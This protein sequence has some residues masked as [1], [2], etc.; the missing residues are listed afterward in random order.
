MSDTLRIVHMLPALTKGGAERVAVDLANSSAR[1]GHQVTVVAGWKVDEQVL[2]NRLDREVDVIYMT[3]KPGGKLQ[4]YSAGL[5]W[6]FTNQAWLSRHDVL[7]LHLTQAAVL[8]T[9]LY[10]IRKLRRATGPAIVETYHSVGMAIP[11]RLRAFHAWNCRRRDAIALMALDPY[12]RD[13]IAR[14]PALAVDLI[15]NGIDAPVGAAPEDEVRAYLDRTG[16]PRSAT[17]IVGTVGQFRAERQPQTLARILIDV[18][19]QTP[20]DVHALMCGSGTELDAVR[21]LVVDAGMSA[22][23]TLP[24]V[25][26]EPRLAMSAISIYLT[27]NVGPHTGIAALEAALCGSA[28]VGLQTHPGRPIAESDWIWSSDTP[29]IVAKHILELLGDGPKTAQIVEKQRDFV[30]RHHSMERVHLRYLR[31]YDRA[32]ST[33]YGEK[34]SQD[35]Q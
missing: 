28:L 1:A 35:K 6:V 24:G 20:N 2:R 32:I 15:P 19:R 10:A 26:N 23:F 13:F 17:Q 8:G 14:N 22:R 34:R 12:W 16:V 7:H 9:V 31:L 25:V 4:R 33:M 30:N 3:E 29:S 11:N 18:L 5:G 21:Q 27:L